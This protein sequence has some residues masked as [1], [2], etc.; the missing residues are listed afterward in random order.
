MFAI[1]KPNQPKVIKY[2]WWNGFNKEEVEKVFPYVGFSR[3]TVHDE[4]PCEITIYM[5]GN[6]VRYIEGGV[7]ICCE[8]AHS[9]R[10]IFT[11]SKKEF[12]EKYNG[13]SEE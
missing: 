9:E 3:R 11:L 13:L 4:D 5:G 7:Y 6:R 2:V 10:D 12:E 1:E 8:V